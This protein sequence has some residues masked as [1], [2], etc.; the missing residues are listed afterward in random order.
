M[1][2]EERYIRALVA[3]LQRITIANG[4]NTN[5]GTRVEVDPPDEHEDDYDWTPTTPPRVVVLPDSVD[6]AG[7]NRHLVNAQQ[8]ISIVGYTNA[9]LPPADDETDVDLALRRR[10]VAYPLLADLLRALFP[11][12]AADAYQDDLDSV[13]TSITYNGH[14]LYPRDD[15]G[16][17]T[18]V[19]IS[20]LVDFKLHLNNP[21]Q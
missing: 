10:A 14:A 16:K 17:T 20:V 7:I 3:R 8:S 11:D 2:R 21:D 18:V 4:F 6:P 9:T 12:G 1:M 13:A 5:G 15:G 19:E